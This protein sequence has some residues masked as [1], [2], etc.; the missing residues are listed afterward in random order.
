MDPVGVAC[1]QNPIITTLRVHIIYHIPIITL[2]YEFVSSSRDW[3]QPE[4]PFWEPCNLHL[5]YRQMPMQASDLRKSAMQV[6][7]RS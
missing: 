1:R 5:Q 7:E 3:I 4:L 6:P 2:I